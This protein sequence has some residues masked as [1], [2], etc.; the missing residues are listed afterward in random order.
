LAT[1]TGRG[2]L[3]VLAA[4]VAAGPVAV[5]DDATVVSVLLYWGHLA[6]ATDDAVLAGANRLAIRNDAGEWE[7]IGFANAALTVPS[8]YCL[9]HLLRGQGGT[10]HAV[11]GAAAGNPVMVLD[12]GADAVSVPTD[13]LGQTLELRAYAGRTDAVGAAFSASV[14]LA[15]ALPL[16]PVHLAATRDAASG[17]VALSWVRCSRSDT[18]SW[19][20]TEAPLDVTPE[21]YAITI[22]DGGAAVRTIPAASPAV[23]YTAVD[24]TADFGSPPA[25]FSFTVAQVSPTLGPGIAATGA[26]H[27]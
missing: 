21:A 6:S 19:A 4:P 7:I 8:T 13:W 12:A 26:F 14:D 10:V 1:L 2:A 27:A 18:D 22:L 5:W 9:T 3:G 17:D 23:T 25:S 16:A 15:P 11:G 20:T 24:Q